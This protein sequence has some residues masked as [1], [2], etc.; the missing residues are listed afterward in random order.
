MHFAG[1]QWLMPIIPATQEAEFRRLAV[2]SHPGQR[3]LE[4]IS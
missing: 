4:I 2:Q 3:I 1:H